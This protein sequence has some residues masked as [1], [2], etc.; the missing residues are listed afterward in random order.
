[1]NW[2]VENLTNAF[3]T[4]NTKMA[5]IWSL[6]AL[7]PQDF[8]GGAVWGVMLNINGGLKAI[9]YALIVLFTAI[10][11]FGGTMNVRE[12][13]RPETALRYFIRF[14]A[15]KTAVGYCMD[16]MLLLFEICGGVASQVAL[17]MSAATAAT[18]SLPQDIINDIESVGFFESIPLWIVSL[19]GSLLITVLSFVL[20]MTVYGRFFRLFMYTAIAPIPIS[21]F[22]GETTAG[23]GKQFIRNYMAVCL[24]GAVVMLALIIFSAMASGD[25]ITTASTP[26]MKVWAYLAEV[27]FNMLICVGLVK[28]SDRLAKELF[29]I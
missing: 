27:V 19:L 8:K 26:V 13:R 16:L 4:W 15:T 12:L 18:V 17:Q 24:E 1:M 14:I 29:G 7:H 28:A 5:E 9:G 2:I 3:A 6:L 20:I 23:H 21:C 25:P 11:I 10:A 22:G